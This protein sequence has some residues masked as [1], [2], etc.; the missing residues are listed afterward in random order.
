MLEALFSATQANDDG[1]ILKTANNKVSLSEYN[2]F[3]NSFY[4]TKSQKRKQVSSNTS[5]DN[6][7]IIKTSRFKQPIASSS[8]QP[9]TTPSQDTSMTTG[10]ALSQL[11]DKLALRPKTPFKL[12]KKITLLYSDYENQLDLDSFI[13]AMNLVSSERKASIFFIMKP[14]DKH[15]C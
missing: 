5:Q 4:Q 12:D 3:L 6:E 2:D 11:K 8:K 10:K 1:I 9:A 7:V 15:D 13:N 14:G